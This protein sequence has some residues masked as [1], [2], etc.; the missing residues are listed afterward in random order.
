MK[1]EHIALWVKDLE[2]MKN[3]YMEYF[4]MNCGEKYENKNKRFSSYF[5]AFESGARIEIMCRPDISEQA[6]RNGVTYGLTHLAISVG[7]KEKVDELTEL[8]RNNG[9][10]IV[11]EPRMTGD[12]FYESIISDPEGNH[13]E[14]T[15]G[16]TLCFMLKNI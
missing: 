14:I 2:G 16:P 7:S 15:D 1:I 5:L 11:G 3:F 4:N 13:I 10:E 12:G 9:F 6:G 8:I